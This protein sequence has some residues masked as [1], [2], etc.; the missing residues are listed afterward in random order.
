MVEWKDD[1]SVGVAEI[2][3]QHQD[4]FNMVNKLESFINHKIG[5]GPEVDALMGF[6]KAYTQSHF[7]YEEMCMRTRM[8]P[9][10]KKNEKAHEYFQNFF[11]EFMV[12]YQFQGSNL[13]MLERLHKILEE[14][15]ISHIMKI[16]VHLKDCVFSIH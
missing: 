3:K 10:K 4:L 12:E 11:G 2:D 9:A 7:T 16:D 15:L 1:Y 8:C 13:E 5:H 14:W 6:L